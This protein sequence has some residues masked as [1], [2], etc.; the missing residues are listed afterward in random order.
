VA[1]RSTEDAGGSAV[2]APAKPEPPVAP[3]VPPQVQPARL[4]YVES[5]A[6]ELDVPDFLK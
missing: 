3:P 1:G 6:E 4:P 5:P 2:P